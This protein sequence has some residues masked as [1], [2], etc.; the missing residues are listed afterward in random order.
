MAGFLLW[1][2]FSHCS[3]ATLGCAHRGSCTPIYPVL[4][5]SYPKPIS[6]KPQRGRHCTDEVFQSRGS[7]PSMESVLLNICFCSSHQSGS[8]CWVSLSI[9]LCLIQ[10]CACPPVWLHL[11]HA[12]FVCFPSPTANLSDLCYSWSWLQAQS[13][14]LRFHRE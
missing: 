8:K 1:W 14:N 4:G 11:L 6:R 3:A 2:L 13:L 7:Q 12:S 9:I 10:T 5:H